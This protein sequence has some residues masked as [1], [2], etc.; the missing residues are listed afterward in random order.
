MIAHDLWVRNA[1]R[2]GLSGSS[3]PHGISYWADLEQRVHASFTRVP[4]AQVG[5]TGRPGAGQ[6]RAS[7]W[8]RQVASLGLCRAGLPEN[9]FAETASDGPGQGAHRTTPAV[10]YGSKQSAVPTDPGGAMTRRPNGK[11][12]K[13]SVAL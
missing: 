9:V 2:A 5:L 8:T 6:P 12:V 3:A 7:S 13:E 1:D 4:G 11:H 10:P